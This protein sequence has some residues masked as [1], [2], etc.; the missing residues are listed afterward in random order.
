VDKTPFDWIAYSLLALLG[1]VAVLFLTIEAWAR[2]Q[3]RTAP[4][5]TPIVPEPVSL[6][7]QEPAIPQPSGVVQAPRPPA[8][9]SHLRGQLQALLNKGVALEQGA[10]SPLL[11]MSIL[12]P[13]TRTEDV[14]AWE[15]EVEAA[16]R[17]RPRDVALFQYEPPRSPLDAIGVTLMTEN[18]LKRRLR[19]RNKQLETII[20]RLP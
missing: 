19:Q 10:T 2:W 8:S 12:T 1:I 4:Q 20:K 13:Q 11:A 14:E 18:P 3:Q 9:V 7:R 5:S 15:A 17:E 16:L 6:S